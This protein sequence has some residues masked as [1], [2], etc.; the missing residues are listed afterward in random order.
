MDRKSIIILVAC[1]LLL[2]FWYPLVYTIYPP[3]PKPADTNTVAQAKAP[4]ST[5]AATNITQTNIFRDTSKT[6]VPS[7]NQPLA[8]SPSAA[9][10]WTSTNQSAADTIT[11]ENEL[12]I[13]TFTSLGG[14][15]KSVKLKNYPETATNGKTKDKNTGP[16]LA[17]LNS[18]SPVPALVAIGD[19]QLQG[20]GI[21][22]LSKIST[23]TGM[24]VR[25]QKELTNGMRWIKDFVISNSY[26][27]NAQ[28][29]IENTTSEPIEV[30]AYDFT[31]GA[32]TPIN[33]YDD[34]TTFMGIIWYDGEDAQFIGDSWFQNRTLGCFPGTPRTFYSGGNSNVFWGAAHNQFFVM[35]VMP[36]TPGAS[37]AATKIDLPRPTPEEIAVN[38]D[39]NLN[40]I[41]FQAAIRSP[42]ATIPPGGSLLKNYKVYAGPKK[43]NLLSKISAS[44]ENDL[45]TVMNYGGFFGFFAKILLL[46]MN[47]LHSFGLS[48]GWT[49]VAITIIVKTLFWPLTNAST[50]SMKRMAELQPQM[51][52]IQE[53]YKDDP[54]KMNAKTMEFMK[55]NRVNPMGGCL[56]MLLQIPVFFGFFKMLQSAVELRGAS[57]LWVR[58]L[59][60]PDTVFT[61][62]GIDFPVNPLPLIMGA[63]MLWQA[64]L[65]PPSPGMDPVQQKI[66]RYMP[67]IFVVFLYN[68]STGLTL[69]WT[70]QNLLSI[71]QMK[72]TKKTQTQEPA[73]PQPAAAKT[74][75]PKKARKRLKS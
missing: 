67:L 37:I 26:L 6:N 55:Q 22:E 75:T 19:E 45:D 40:P 8:Q 58:D 15:I 7:R 38:K 24:V 50:K 39:L 63:S 33:A 52:A 49:I 47:G 72:L 69:Y 31:I 30:P 43:Y 21:F 46:S 18:P 16:E 5:T 35:A 62:P 28:V 64:R 13:Y 34:K 73:K 44:M 56:P 48:Y 59:S 9:A 68:Y 53:K 27:L 66:M 74:A 10:P 32:S 29:K 11:V 12:A 42:D 65:T 70:V 20:N 23:S 14:G 36:E 71:V 57:F 2:I 3:E 1:F 54:K 25:A 41:G 51:K 17:T 61:V 60:Q 4:E